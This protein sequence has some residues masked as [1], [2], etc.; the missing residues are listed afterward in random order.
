M[1]LPQYL[2]QQLPGPPTFP[3]LPTE[4]H[5]QFPCSKMSQREAHHLLVNP[6]RPAWLMA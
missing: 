1:G 2:L 4:P 3:Q 6:D 5:S